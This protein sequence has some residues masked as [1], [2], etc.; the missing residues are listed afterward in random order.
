LCSFD[1]LLEDHAPALGDRLLHRAA[2]V[3]GDELERPAVQPARG[4]R[5]VHRDL[6]AGADG[7][8]DEGEAAAV[9]VDQAELHRL[10]ARLRRNRRGAQRQRKKECNA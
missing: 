10:A 8:G 1:P 5:L 9:D 7:V 3:G 4:V 2:H 6:E